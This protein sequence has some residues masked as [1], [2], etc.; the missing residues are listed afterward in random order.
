MKIFHLSSPVM[1]AHMIRQ[2]RATPP[3]FQHSYQTILNQS[4]SIIHKTVIE[5]T[6]LS[7]GSLSTMSSFTQKLGPGW[8]RINKNNY[9]NQGKMDDLPNK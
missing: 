8:E 2:G 7:H 9:F 3:D 5:P 4:K 6:Q 1:I